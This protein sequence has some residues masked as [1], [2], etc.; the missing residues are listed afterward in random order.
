MSEG[1]GNGWSIP[2]LTPEADARHRKAQ[3]SHRGRAS[4]AKGANG[5]RDVLS[6][7]RDVMRNVESELTEAGFTFVA[8]SEFA[9]R[10]RLERGTSS[11][12]I[13]NIPIISIEVKRN[14]RLNINSAWEQC[15]RQS[16]GGLLPTL[17]YRYNRE[18]WRVRTWIALTHYNGTGAPVSYAVGEVSLVDF[19]T[20]FARLYRE[21]LTAGLAT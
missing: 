14:E 9:T 12:D 18:P 20:Y 17:V 11:R 2:A 6:A 13:G 10:K 3:A 19:L 21:F 4:A 16:D 7:F 1:T 8:R 15:V 5:E